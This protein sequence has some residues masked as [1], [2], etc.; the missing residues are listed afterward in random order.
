MQVF[1]EPRVHRRPRHVVVVVREVEHLAAV[2]VLLFPEHAVQPLQFGIAFGH[3]LLRPVVGR[4]HGLRLRS[5][6]RGQLDIAGS[7]S[8]QRAV[9][10]RASALH[11]GRHH[12]VWKS[13]DGAR[14][15]RAQQDRLSSAA[16]ATGHGDPFAINVRQRLQKVQAAD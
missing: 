4:G 16:A 2:D 5:E 15:D 3:H 9:F 1:V 6:Q 14:I 8:Q 7:D 12:S 13:S 11:R 10:A